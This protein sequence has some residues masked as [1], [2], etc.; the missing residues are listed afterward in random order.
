MKNNTLTA[1]SSVFEKNIFT[2]SFRL[3]MKDNSG[4]M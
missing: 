1:D 3:Y 2:S 4:K